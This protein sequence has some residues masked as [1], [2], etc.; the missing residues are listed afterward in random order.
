VAAGTPGGQELWAYVP[1][2]VHPK[3]PGRANPVFE[4]EFLVDGTP[5]TSTISGF[6][7]IGRILVGGLGK[8]GAGYYALDITSGT[9][10]TEADVAAKV[11]WEFKPANMGYSFG[12]PL[13][14]NTARGWRVVVASGLRN[15]AGTDGTGGDG[16]GHV[17]VLN[18]DNG[19][20]DRE[21][22]TPTTFGSSTAG[23]G[24][25][26][27]AAPSNL[28]AGSAI[29]Y[30]YGGDLQGNVWRID[31]NATT[32]SAPVRIAAVKAPDGTAQ[33][34][35]AAPVVSLLIGSATKFFVY[36]GTGQYFSVDDVPGT[37]TPDASSSQVQTLYGILDD[38]SV[39]A[40]TLPSTR[41]TGACPANGGNGDLACQTIT[42]N[43]DGT[44][45]TSHNA[46]DL[47]RKRGFYVDLPISGGRVNTQP[48]LTSGGTLVV[49]VN[50]PSNVICNPGGSS[51]LIQLSALTGGAIATA[52][53]GVDYYQAVFTLADALSSR[54]VIVTTSTGPRALLR[55]SDK[56]TQ[57]R[58]INQT[59]SVAAGFR[60]IY[61]R[62]LN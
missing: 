58:E 25:A 35:S 9:A 22:I 4:H 31:L 52:F 61:M 8:G 39:A 43:A 1:S 49:A 54:P 40:P 15:D 59:A 42:Q 32:L 19:S 14:V 16:R 36:F 48:A 41:N 26:Y 57:S 5:A 29:R 37:A 13:I 60:R 3:L 2:L 47:S 38:T 62:P 45:T 53:G 33:P 28:S 7:T 30:V 44:F 46:V 51:F 34:I 23:L 6:G 55:L 56:T 11:L 50:D 21:F 20:I 10:A 27:L 12:T 24:L 17:W 18:P